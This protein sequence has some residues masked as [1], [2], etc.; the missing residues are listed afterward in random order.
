M[1]DFYNIYSREK[2]LGIRYRKIRLNVERE[3]CMQEIVCGWAVSDSWSIVLL[4]LDK[5]VT[6]RL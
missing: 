4:I 2:G 1:D 6:D 5:V 3:K